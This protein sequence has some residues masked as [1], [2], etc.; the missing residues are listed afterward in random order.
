MGLC[1][2]VSTREFTMLRSILHDPTRSHPTYDPSTIQ[3]DF[4]WW[5]R[6]I[7]LSY[8]FTREFDSLDLL[9]PCQYRLCASLGYLIMYIAK[10]LFLENGLKFDMYCKWVET[11]VTC[12]GNYLKADLQLFVQRR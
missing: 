10:D 11:H 7:V 5:A 9:N 12:P 6:K 2:I 4:S 1:K 3:H 8:V